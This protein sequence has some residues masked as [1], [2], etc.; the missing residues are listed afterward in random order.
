MP[1]GAGKSL[2][3]LFAALMQPGITV[4]IEPIRSL[5][6][7]QVMNLHALRIHSC[8]AI[9]S[10]MNGIQKS[11]AMKAFADGRYQFTYLSPERF[12]IDDFRKVV[13]TMA[14]CG[15]WC[16]YCVI[17]EAHCVS[18]WG[19][20]FRTSYLWL[21]KNAREQLSPKIEELTGLKEITFMALTGT[22]SYDVLADIR[23]ELDIRDRLSI[24]TPSN[25]E[26]KEL[27]F[28]IWTMG[29]QELDPDDDNETDQRHLEA[30]KLLQQAPEVLQ[31]NTDWI[32]YLRP[33]GSDTKAAILFCPHARGTLGVADRPTKQGPRIGFYSDLQQHEPSIATYL[34][35]YSAQETTESNIKT[36]AEFKAN[37][38]SVLVATKAFGMGVDKPNIRQVIHAVMP[39]SIESY[40]QEAGRAGRDRQ[41]S[42]CTII[43]N[44]GFVI[45]K[46]GTETNLDLSVNYFFYNQAFPERTVEQKKMQLF[47]TEP[48]QVV[49]NR[50]RNV[51]EAIGERVGF[52]VKI[53]PQIQQVAV[54]FWDDT[55][56]RYIHCGSFRANNS[57]TPT[58]N[59]IAGYEQDIR[60]V[61]E[62]AEVALRE[63]IDFCSNQPIRNQLLAVVP[64]SKPLS[65]LEL[66]SS[67]RPGQS[68]D[69]TIPFT[70]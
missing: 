61:M 14:A 21:G 70:V 15:R 5:M 45:H 43:Y 46:D 31:S 41:P 39:P 29:N 49:N 40:Y 50:I 9:N 68:F 36:Q 33:S 13:T 1:T 28:Q 8:V 12:W 60:L 19:H 48:L 3:F 47:L 56:R 54:Q 62:A 32:E 66:L 23:R 64:S 63:Q 17:D 24:I 69:E 22:A 6:M 34:G 10:L 27:Q 18:E 11:Q 42:L 37:K 35:K 57:F 26:R 65:L 2:T 67:I 55:H 38:I 58:I 20:D 52:S 4:V 25:F 59:N 51:K 7:D 16:L 44:P 30:I 53:E